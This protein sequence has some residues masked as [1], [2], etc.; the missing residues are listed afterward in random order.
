MQSMNNFLGIVLQTLQMYS[1]CDH[2]PTMTVQQLQEQ[3]RIVYAKYVHMKTIS[4][5]FFHNDKYQQSPP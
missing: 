5:T 4:S 2:P 1:L 3:K